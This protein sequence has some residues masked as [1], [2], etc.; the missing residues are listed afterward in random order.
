[1]L[2]RQESTLPALPAFNHRG[3]HVGSAFDLLHSDCLVD[4]HVTGMNETH[5]FLALALPVGTQR[6]FVR[7]LESLAGLFH[8]LDGK[9][10]STLSQVKVLSPSGQEQAAANRALCQETACKVFDGLIRQGLDIKEATKRTNK[11]LK[12]TG[13]PW[14]SF[15]V[16]SDLLRK[17]GR[18]RRMKGGKA[19]NIAL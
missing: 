11:T 7:L 10:K 9:E 2:V 12:A 3:N 1:M 13:H 16:V 19:R 14:A 18:F 5:V 17:S 15:E 4:Y 6:H 8:I